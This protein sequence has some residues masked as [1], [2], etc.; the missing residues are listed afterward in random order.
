VRRLINTALREDRAHRDRTSRAVL[1]PALRI[2]ARLIAKAPGVLAG[3]QAA[4]M[5]FTALDPSLRCRLHRSSG[6]RL[7][8]GTPLLTIDGRAR[9]IF[10]AE[11]TAL[12]LLSHLSGIATLTAAY[13]RQVRG[14]KAV[15]LDTRKTLPG[16]RGLEKDAVRAG[17]GRSH[18]A[19]LAEAILIKTNHLRALQRSAF[20]VQ[21]AKVIQQAVNKVKRAY[22][23]KPVEVEVVNLAEFKAAL[24]ARPRMVL[25]D[26]WSLPDIRK[27]VSLRNCTLHA[28]RSTLALEVSGGVTLANVRAIARA[29]VDRISIGRL[30][31]SAPALDMALRVQ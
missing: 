8:P 15:I 31:H 10:A 26:N 4:A 27:A 20:S 9:S 23:N 1:P 17:G 21:R 14:T 29:G 28:K 22:P 18:R 13:V 24:A 30:T 3:V 16:L 19:D 6:A 5:V 2:R 7:A 25:L 11:R 12:N